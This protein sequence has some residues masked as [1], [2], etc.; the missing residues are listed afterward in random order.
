MSDTR[1]LPCKCSAVITDVDVTLVDDEKR[2]TLRAKS[3]VA[4]LRARGIIFSSIRSRGCGRF[5][6][7]HV[8]GLA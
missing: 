4:E 8:G 1:A 5:K 3:A 2:L 7:A 6:A